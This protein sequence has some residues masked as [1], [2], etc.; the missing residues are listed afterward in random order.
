VV[1]NTYAITADSATASSQLAAAKKEWN[2][3]L[4]TYS[5]G[6]PKYDG[7]PDNWGEI[8]EPKLAEI[9]QKYP[10]VVVNQET[11]SLFS[12]NLGIR[13]GVTGIGG[14]GNVVNADDAYQASLAAKTTA[15]NNLA[16]AQTR[17]DAAKKENDRLLNQIGTTADTSPD[18]AGTATKPAYNPLASNN[19]T[20]TSTTTSRDRQDVSSANTKPVTQNGDAAST[21]GTDPFDQAGRTGNASLSDLANTASARNDI[22]DTSDD[23]GT[24]TG[25]GSPNGTSTGTGAGSTGTGTGGSSNNSGPVSVG[26]QGQGA[27][28]K[29]GQ[30]GTQNNPQIKLRPNKLHE[31]V[32]WTYQIGWYM[33]DLGTFNSFTESNTESPALRQRPLMRSGGFVKT[34]KGLDFDLSLISLRTKGVIGN[35]H[36][37]PSANLFEIEMEVME[38][39]GVSLLARLKTI[40]DSMPGGPHDSFQ[41]PYLLEIKWLGYTDTG[42]PVNN[43]P[44]TGPK[45]IPVQIINITF[46]ITSAGTVYNITMVPYTQQGINQIYG[47]L[48][49]DIVLYGDSLESLL[50]TGDHSLKAALIKKA[51]GDVDE[52]KALYPDIY[53]FEISSFD[54]NRGKNDKLARD[55]ITFAH[56][57]GEGTLIMRRGMDRDRQGAND[58]NSQYFVA[59]GGSQIKDVITSL[60]KNSKY[61][62]DKIAATPN[63]DKENPMEL[64]KVV[65]MIRNLGKFD[66]IRNVYQKEIVYKVMPYY[67]YGEVHENVGQAPVDKRG[68][69][70]EYNWIFTGK[71]SDILDLELNY[72]VMYFQISEKSSTQKGAVNT[73][74]NVEQAPQSTNPDTDSAIRRKLQT[75]NVAST[76]IPKGFRPSTV[77][78]Y[79]DHQLNSPN[80]ADLVALDV[81]II[82]DPDWIP[83]DRSIRPKGLDINAIN[84]GFVD[85]DYTKGIATDVDSIYVKFSFR[86]PR[87]YSDTT[88][89]MQLSEDQ[90]LISGVY[91][92]ITVES[93]FDNGRFTQT[94][95]LVRAPTQKE[96]TVEKTQ[97]TSTERVTAPTTPFNAVRP[98][99]IPNNSPNLN[100]QYTTSNF[101]GRPDYSG[102]LNPDWIDINANQS[103]FGT[104]PNPALDEQKAYENKLN[105]IINGGPINYAPVNKAPSA[106]EDAGPMPSV[107][108]MGNVTQ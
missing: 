7:Y 88:G 60:A 25:A 78:E 75:G 72:N 79:F 54:A 26:Q 50:K 37:S 74:T 103:G 99:Y 46:K 4:N 64:L 96:N 83:Q 84:S 102:Q 49:Q 39:Y 2:A 15:Q 20:G 30:G 40:A 34:G 36:N 52:K 42:A 9:L 66:P 91:K 19:L 48:R 56:E 27:L 82:G 47:T 41:I 71:N 35:N 70:K 62:Q 53:D 80:N 28:P 10:A 38:P 67:V 94:L 44:E 31:Y 5:K 17:A 63:S 16:A 3:F 73:G 98:E 85:D 93:N 11:G 1:D 101:P 92:V 69:V 89:I 90:T 61:F 23:S 45:L 106:A 97:T 55:K 33:L 59:R 86:T 22:A 104:A 12:N 68:M 105:A 95:N 21:V 108:A 107:D 65:P 32:N 81:T 51:Q 76:N 24:S 8:A 13:P 58:P 43:I 57:G 87:D 6:D 18:L 14:P 29:A 100:P 77:E